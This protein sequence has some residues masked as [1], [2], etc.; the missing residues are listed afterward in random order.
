MTHVK[1]LSE[2]EHH[3]S[4]R[5]LFTLV[6]RT[7]LLPA[8]LSCHTT[9]KLPSPDMEREGHSEKP[10]LLLILI[11]SLNRSELVL[12]NIYLSTDMALL[13]PDDFLVIKK[14]KGTVNRIVNGAMLAEPLLHVNVASEVERGMLGIAVSNVTNRT[15]IGNNSLTTERGPYVF[16]YY[17]NQ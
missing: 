14:S 11:N 12:R 15:N 17:M 7:S 6:S 2:G 3:Y 16:L 5:E 9:N 10:S 1:Q 8:V 13:G 4:L